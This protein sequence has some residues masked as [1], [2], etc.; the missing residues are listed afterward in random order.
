MRPVFSARPHSP[1]RA[2]DD[3]DDDDDDATAPDSDVAALGDAV[4]AVRRREEG[5]LVHGGVPLRR[6][7]SR[8]PARPG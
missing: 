5:A 7:V 1:L 3:D 8:A 2:A 4:P 6:A